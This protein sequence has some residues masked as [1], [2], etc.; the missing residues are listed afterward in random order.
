MAP[1]DAPLLYKDAATGMTP[2]EHKG[3]GT[4]KID[5]LIME[6]GPGFP[7]LF[8]IPS[9]DIKTY[10]MPDIKKPKTKNGDISKNK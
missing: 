3:M 2:H 9:F 1:L 4:P 8:E 10:N 6:N 7:K 5:A